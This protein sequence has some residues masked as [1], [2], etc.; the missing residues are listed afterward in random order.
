V[1]ALIGDVLANDKP[2]IL[3]FLKSFSG[4]Y[5]EANDDM[6]RKIIALTPKDPSKGM[7]DEANKRPDEPASWAYK[8]LVDR[9]SWI[10]AG[11]EREAKRIMK[12]AMEGIAN[13]D[14]F[15]DT[16]RDSKY[17]EA[18]LELARAKRFNP[19]DPEIAQA[20]RPCRRVARS[21]RRMSRKPWNPPV[22]R[23][24]WRASRALA[25]YPDLARR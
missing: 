10:Q 16:V 21:P 5:G 4:A 7:Y 18:E 25:P 2:R 19:K 12:N 3:A 23:P 1:L 17:A 13:A 14:F 11:P 15:Q 20:S 6:D 22:S 9:L 8:K 24:M